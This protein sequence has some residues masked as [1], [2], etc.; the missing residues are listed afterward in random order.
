MNIRFGLG[1]L[2]AMA[3][4]SLTWAEDWPQFR[5]PGGTGVVN[6]DL[7]PPDRFTTRENVAWKTAIPGQGWSGPVVAAGRV[8]VTT[9][10]GPEKVKAPKTG[11]YAPLDNSTAKGE[12]KWKVLCLDA[13]SGKV[14][15]E[16]TAHK[17]APQHPIHVKGSYAPETPIADAERVYAYFGNVGMFCFD[18]DGKE[19]WSKSW[20]VFPT[21]VNWGTGASPI[22]H[23]ER[24]YI[25]N[26]NEKKSFL[27]ALDKKTGKEIWTVD[28]E[29]KSNWATPFVWETP[30]RT[31]IV[32]V[33]TG[34]VRSYDETG[35][36]LWTMGG[37]S[38]ICVPAPV[39]GQ[40][41]LFISSGYEFG[42][43]RPV[44]A[45]KPGASGDIT[46]PKDGPP[47]P[48]V[49]WHRD[50]IGAYHPTPLLL[51]DNLYVLYSTGFISC[52]DA[53]T[54]KTVYEKQRLG[55]TFTA[56]PWSYAGK[57]FCLSEE[58]IT[59]TIQAGP[60]FKILARSPLDEVTLATPA[61]ADGRLFLRTAT[62]LYCFA[63][64]S[65]ARA[66]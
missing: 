15:W 6:G 40:G 5:G 64:K 39:A 14:L 11:Y 36:L 9:C 2:G 25:V 41:L 3:L 22:L 8:Y 20:G 27:V 51:G 66:K 61:I 44:V 54:G 34:K 59:T 30:G 35:K 55:G 24:I 60:E 33:G 1:I 37:M 23:K 62:M 18:R 28:R 42:R 19:L 65:Q 16:R 52:F 26:D 48:F 21:R 29:E 12:H 47:G 53:K 32:T 43:P 10:E 31:E 63:N 49:A 46:P 57:I 4:V 56:S 58:G 50:S 45:V 17:G 13:Q 38:S 7:L